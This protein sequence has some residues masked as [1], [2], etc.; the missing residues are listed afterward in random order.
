[1]TT[2]EQGPQP[3][4]GEP[5]L[6]RLAGKPLV[7]L[8]AGLAF[9][10][11]PLT[12]VSPLTRALGG[13]EPLYL[14]LTLVITS[15]SYTA[16]VRLFERRPV[17]ELTG[18]HAGRELALGAL[19]G[20]GLI[21]A[22]VGI[23]ALLG[24]YRLRG[25]GD[26]TA[27]GP[28]LSLS[29]YSGFVEELVS[30]GVVFRILDE[31]LGSWPALLLSALTF[32]FLHSTNPGATF[33][34]GLS[35]A[36]SAGLLLGALF[37]LTRRLWAPIGLHFAWNLTEGGVFGLAVSGFP[38]KGL[39]QSDLKGPELLTGGAF[40]I[41]AS[42]LVIV[43]GVALTAPLLLRAARTGRLTPASWGRRSPQQILHPSALAAPA[44]P[45]APS[46]AENI[47]ETL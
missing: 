43:L 7:R 25:A 20:G 17:S 26:W 15:V 23:L 39:L 8:L 30:R 35:I 34:S 37:L 47:D 12:A 36:I 31:W 3:C 46:A 45:S 2:D 16:F 42:V 41:E 13:G 11:A 33:L 18:Q 38:Q 14:T 22:L 28:A 1:M 4:P 6:R 24:F 27:A 19:L 32:G 29:A 21:A 44:E 10:L 5:A 40:G 9:V